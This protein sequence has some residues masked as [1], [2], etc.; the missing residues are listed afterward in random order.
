MAQFGTEKV[1]GLGNTKKPRV[2]SRAWF[3]TWNNYTA[4]EMAQIHKKFTEINGLSFAF[5]EE[6]GKEGTKHLQGVIR[7]KNPMG[8]AFQDEYSNKIHWE[9]CR[10][11]K[12]AIKYCTKR[13]TRS[14]KVLHNIAGLKVRKSIKDPL[15]GKELY[16][17]QNKVLDILNKEPEDRL[18]Y[19]IWDPRGNS[20][21]SSLAKHLVLKR[22]ALVVG[23]RARDAQFAIANLVNDEDNARD[24]DIVIFDIARSQLNKVSY[25]AIESIKNGMFFSSKY[26]SGQCVFNVPHVLVFANAEP[27]YGNL[28]LDRWVIINSM[29]GQPSR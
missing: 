24:P 19:W 15:A 11:W 9:R 1:S 5:Q 27:A 22:N 17:W 4:V 12:K 21:K 14:G 13:D 16:A 3:F 23:G 7:F 6:T 20:G 10:S 28:S 29:V 26:E 18:I 25:V 2:R 8:M